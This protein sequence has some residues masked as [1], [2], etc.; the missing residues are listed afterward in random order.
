MLDRIQSSCI[1][2]VMCVLAVWLVGYTGFRQCRSYSITGLLQ[3]GGL[4]SASK[5]L[6]FPSLTSTPLETHSLTSLS[7]VLL[8]SED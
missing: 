7:D 5:P 6:N 3:R 1:C 8:C 2:K 4:D